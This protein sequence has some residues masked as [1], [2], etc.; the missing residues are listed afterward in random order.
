VLVRY[1]TSC[2][3]LD[4]LEEARRERYVDGCGAFLTDW[5]LRVVSAFA[6]I[7]LGGR[8]CVCGQA[9]CCLPLTGVVDYRVLAET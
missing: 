5:Y 2:P 3:A 4:G 7:L 6:L 1:R 9:V 8:V